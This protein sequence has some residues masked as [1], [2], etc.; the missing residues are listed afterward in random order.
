MA[1]VV[2]VVSQFHAWLRGPREQFFISE[3][4]LLMAMNDKQVFAILM[5]LRKRVRQL[6]LVTGLRQDKKSKSG[7][8]AVSQPKVGAE[9]S[10]A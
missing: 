2:A 8:G 1:G 3:V 6:E 9:R 7:A 4:F 5:D 10:E